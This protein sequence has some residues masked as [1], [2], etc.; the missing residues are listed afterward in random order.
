MGLAYGK[1]RAGDVL[2]SL[3]VKGK[4]VALNRDYLLGDYMWYF[5][6]GDT[7]RI[8]VNRGGVQTTVSIVLTGNPTSIS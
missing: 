7:V 4:E 3:T 2:I 6:S 8:T 5:K 1:L